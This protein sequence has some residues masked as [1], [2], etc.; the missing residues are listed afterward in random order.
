MV[1]DETFSQMLPAFRQLLA[2][3]TA[4]SNTLGNGVATCTVDDG[5]QFQDFLIVFDAS[6]EVAMHVFHCLLPSL[7]NME[8]RQLIHLGLA[9][10]GLVEYTSFPL[11]RPKLN[12][13]V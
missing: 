7:P 2:F 5:L 9:P 8:R 13:L 12:W 1:V 4:F 3:A 10:S 6:I 11:V